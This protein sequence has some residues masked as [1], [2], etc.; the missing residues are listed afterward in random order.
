[1]A[2]S[3]YYLK[4]NSEHL[5]Q[6]VFVK[7]K[8]K[9][10]KPLQFLNNRKLKD[11]LIDK[12]VTTLPFISGNDSSDTEDLEIL[13]LESSA[14]GSIEKVH[15]GNLVGFIG[16][17][18]VQINIQS[19]FCDA[20]DGKND[21]FLL[22]MLSKVMSFNLVN[23]ETGSS[24]N[25]ELDLLYCLFP[26][27]LHEA[28]SQGLYKQYIRKEYND[29][30]LKG[31]I[32]F[33][34]QIRR[35]NPPNGRIAYHTREFSYDNDL[36][37][38]IR[39]TIEFMGNNP[40]GKNILNNSQDT[41]WCVRQIVQ[42]TPNYQKGQRRAVIHANIR[43]FSHPYY[44]KY[45][46]LQ[47][48]CMSILR[49]EQMSFGNSDQKVHGLLIDAAWLWEEYIARLLSEKSSGLA[50]YTRNNAF[51]LFEK[52]DGSKFQTVIPDYYDPEKHIVADAKYIPLQR[53]DHLSADR[54]AP[55]YYK[56]IMYMYRFQAK[57]GFLFHPCRQNELTELS[58][59]YRLEDDVCIHCTY[60]IEERSD[61]HLHKVGMVIPRS[62]QKMKLQE[63]SMDMQKAEEQFV[64]TVESLLPS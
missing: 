33:P 17:G 25:Q 29:S 18:D 11:L 58:E 24:K 3:N 8:T 35:N 7:G 28:L 27:I 34:R 26:R 56:T 61:C 36:T 13:H 45:K 19:R 57:E 14:D 31:V 40:F 22:H 59:E 6:K 1:M 50:H 49:H 42:A 62:T 52:E 16:I 51:R 37:E 12:A 60:S 48:L 55:I 32:D 2:I 64:K 15:T 63:F 41:N 54:A 23:L 53:W 5:F 38:L 47:R 10:S 9:V 30:N 39:H 4:D 20:Q 43:P 44:T 46:P 21:F